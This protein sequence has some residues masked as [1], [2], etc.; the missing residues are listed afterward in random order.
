MLTPQL[1]MEVFIALQALVD[2]D[3][4]SASGAAEVLAA[5][6]A[7]SRFSMI[8]MFLSQAE[9]RTVAG[10]LTSLQEIAPMAVDWSAC[11]SC[12]GV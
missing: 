8:T 6:T 10:L 11:R 7:V 9:R 12:Y 1:L 4:P 2:D 3:R 5:L